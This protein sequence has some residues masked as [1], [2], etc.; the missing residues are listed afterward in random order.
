MNLNSLKS[1]GFITAGKKKDY[2]ILK[3]NKGIILSYNDGNF[4]GFL[5]KIL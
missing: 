2:T 1:K 3:S 4:E 5:K